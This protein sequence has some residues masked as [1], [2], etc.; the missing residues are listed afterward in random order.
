MKSDTRNVQGRDGTMPAPSPGNNGVIRQ[1]AT[2]YGFTEPPKHA[3]NKGRLI[4]L[5]LKSGAVTFTPKLEHPEPTSS[6]TPDGVGSINSLYSELGQGYIDYVSVLENAFSNQKDARSTQKTL[7]HWSPY[8]APT[9]S[10]NTFSFPQ[11][12]QLQTA[13][14]RIRIRSGNRTETPSAHVHKLL[15]QP[16][17]FAVDLCN[18]PYNSHKNMPP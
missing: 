1:P 17:I 7:F 14:P 9:A 12:H 16:N 8:N 2:R 5:P 10:G 6:P 15:D 4:P 13:R 18:C 3:N 11:Q